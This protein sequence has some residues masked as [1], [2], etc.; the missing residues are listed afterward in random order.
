MVVRGSEPTPNVL[1]IEDLHLEGEILLQL[2]KEG[3]I[4][5]VLTF[6]MIMTKKG[7]LMPRVL[8]ASAGHVMKLVETLVPIISKTEL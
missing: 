7:S 3:K 5:A 1:I 4:S 2:Y 6:L 8:F